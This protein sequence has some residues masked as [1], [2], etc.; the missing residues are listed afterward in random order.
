M[1]RSC[2]LLTITAVA[3]LCMSTVAWAQPRGGF[4]GPGGFGGG[5]GFG[6]GLLGLARLEAVQKEIGAGSDQISAIQK[7]GEELRGERGGNP[8]GERP[9]FQN[10]SAEEREKLF[11]EMR[12]RG[13]KQAATA[14]A[15][16]AEILKP[17]Q[18]SRLEEISLQVRGTTALADPKVAEKL[19]LSDEQKSKLKEV[20][21][22]NMEVM[23]S[24]M[25]ELGQDGNREGLREKMQELR[26][27]GEAKVLAVLTTE[28]KATLDKL[29]GKAFQIPEG[30]GRGGPGGQGG[31]RQRRGEGT[32][33]GNRST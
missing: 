28:Q 4:G 16:L 23:R 29:K 17:Q 14:H 24:K 18:I 20:T 1:K 19:K 5:F 21:S 10:M 13:E 11:A 7:L 31:G 12:A 2:S 33:S 27:Q 3:V 15:K 32:T 8:G 6:G 26:K 9:N 22:A 25:Q 30:A